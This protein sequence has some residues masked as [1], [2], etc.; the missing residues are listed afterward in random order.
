MGGTFW[1]SVIDSFWARFHSF[2]LIHL[3]P[4][5]W[6][7]GRWWPT[8]VH[9]Y[10]TYNMNTNMKLSPYVHKQIYIQYTVH[11]FGQSRMISPDHHP[12]KWAPNYGWWIIIV[13]HSLPIYFLYIYIH[14]ILIPREVPICLLKFQSVSQPKS[15]EMPKETGVLKTEHVEPSTPLWQKLTFL[16]QLERNYTPTLS[17]LRRFTAS[18][19]N[20]KQQGDVRLLFFR[21]WKLN[22]SEN[23]RHLFKVCKKILITSAKLALAVVQSGARVFAWRFGMANERSEIPFVSLKWIRSFG[24]DT[25]PLCIWSYFQPVNM[26]LVVTCHW[27]NGQRL[28]KVRRTYRTWEGLTISEEQ[29]KSIRFWTLEMSEQGPKKISR[30]SWCCS[31]AR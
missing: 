20:R 31:K 1:A 7:A 25:R 8:W 21:K 6:V 16:M 26:N 10:Y 14:V 19:L 17:Y 30:S 3:L 11:M 9:M 13:Y 28:H 5:L 29:P 18:F 4:Y 2:F 15:V 24:K 12:P 22:D 23:P 27:Q